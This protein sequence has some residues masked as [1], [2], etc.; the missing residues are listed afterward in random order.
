MCR[1]HEET[2]NLKIIL[3][4]DVSDSKEIAGRFGHLFIINI[5]KCV[6]H[7]V[8]CKRLV[9]G[10]LRLSDLVLMVR[11]DQILAAC[12]DIDLISKILLAHDRAL[13]MPAGT[14]LAPG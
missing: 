1:K 12:M 3:F 13:N 2:K 14:S 6:V 11:E 8:F 4:T 10:S 9:I 7:P 5:Q